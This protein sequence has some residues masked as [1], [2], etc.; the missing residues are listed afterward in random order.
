MKKLMIKG[1]LFLLTTIFFGA[2]LQASPSLSV[3]KNAF[4]DF[5]VMATKYRNMNA[6]WV[7]LDKPTPL[8][9]YA[10]G[11]I[12][13]YKVQIDK[14]TRICKPRLDDKGLPIKIER[15]DKQEVFDTI[16]SMM[17][18]IAT[19]IEGKPDFEN[20]EIAMFNKFFDDDE[21]GGTMKSPHAI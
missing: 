11:L 13:F 10:N 21:N 7:N 6:S 5:K 20:I 17:G 4:P 3:R 19:E 2:M 15:F 12:S 18:F 1:F 14:G 16:Y 9:E 8:F